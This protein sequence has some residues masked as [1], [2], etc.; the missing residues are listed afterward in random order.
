V[1]DAI[2]RACRSGVA[3][4]RPV[5]GG[6]INEALFVE[7]EDGRELFVKHRAD[8]PPGFY[9]AEAAGL[10]WLSSVGALPLPA[11][12]AVEETFLALG[13]VASAAR[14]AGFDAAL[15]RGLARLHAAGASRHGATGDGG[16]TFIGPLRL[17]NDSATSDSWAAFYAERRLAPLLEMAAGARA[18]PSGAGR[19]IESVIGRLGE[20]CGPEE[21]V[22]RL[23]GDL[24]SGNVM[25]GPDGEP[26][27]VDPAAY[28]G[29]R[30][31]DLAMLSL[32]GSPGPEFLAAYEDAGPRLADGHEERVELFQL[33]PLLVHAVLFGGGYGTA[34]DRAAAC[35]R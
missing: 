17:A 35:Y 32:F 2:A 26:V 24:W 31:I 4:S 23:H 13:W 5:A 22:A 6:S 34:A 8:P 10:E 9:A 3:R 30:E 27:L 20:L 14:A 12:V 21:P 11:A 15:G 25:T 28:G 18:L 19:R 33:L 1:I 29:H 7:L 16:P